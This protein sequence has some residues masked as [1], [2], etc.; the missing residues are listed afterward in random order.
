MGPLCFVSYTKEITDLLINSVK[1]SYMVMVKK[2]RK[3]KKGDKVVRLVNHPI[4]NGR[5]RQQRWNRVRIFDPG[6]DPVSS[7]NDVKSRNVLT[8]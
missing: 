6:P 3:R 7:P 8:S 5:E 1:L 4:Y 2:K